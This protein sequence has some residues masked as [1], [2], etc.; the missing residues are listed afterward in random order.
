MYSVVQAEADS[1]LCEGRELQVMFGRKFYAREC[2]GGI[3]M[4]LYICI[5]YIYIL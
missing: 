5:I 4:Y 3:N 2:I 1:K